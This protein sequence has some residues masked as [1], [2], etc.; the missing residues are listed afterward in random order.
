MDKHK[1]AIDMM[2]V[3]LG[4]EIMKQFVGLKPVLKR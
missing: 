4:G 2:K 1:E 3:K